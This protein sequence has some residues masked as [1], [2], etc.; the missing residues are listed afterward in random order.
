MADSSFTLKITAI[1][2]FIPLRLL[3]LYTRLMP[4]TPNACFKY[5]KKYLFLSLNGFTVKDEQRSGMKELDRFDTAFP[6]CTN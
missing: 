3:A 5:E 4:V 2:L 6:L 1:I